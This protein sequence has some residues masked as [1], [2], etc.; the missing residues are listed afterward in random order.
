MEATSLCLRYRSVLLRTD[1]DIARGCAGRP[2]APFG[3]AGEVAIAPMEGELLSTSLN[4]V[5]VDATVSEAYRQY[6]IR[7]DC[8]ENCRQVSLQFVAK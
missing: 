6:C 5:Q 2:L 3:A 8:F 4:E 7:C 1:V